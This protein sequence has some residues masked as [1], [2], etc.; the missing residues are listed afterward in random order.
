LSGDSGRL[1]CSYRVELKNADG[2]WYLL[3]IGAETE[4]VG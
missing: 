1:L 4:E 3:S 2:R